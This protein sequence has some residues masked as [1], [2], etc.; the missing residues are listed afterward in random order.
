[1]FALN[2]MFVALGLAI[3]SSYVFFDMS[4]FLRFAYMCLR[5]ISVKP[6]AALLE[7]CVVNGKRVFFLDRVRSQTGCEPTGC[8]F[9]FLTIM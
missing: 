9:F 2:K 6:H 7:D 1:M 8:E 4:Y 5:S 3:S